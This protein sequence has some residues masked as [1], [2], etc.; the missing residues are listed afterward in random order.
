MAFTA[1]VVY[2]ERWG[3]TF[4]VFYSVC[5]VYGAPGLDFCGVL[6]CL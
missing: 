3:W 1:F 5:S 2:M 6:Q 4:V